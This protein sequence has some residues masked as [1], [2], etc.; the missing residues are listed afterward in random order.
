[1]F[2]VCS[3]LNLRSS[4]VVSA[5]IKGYGVNGAICGAL[6]YG[7]FDQIYVQSE[8]NIKLLS[9]SSSPQIG[10]LFG[11]ITDFSSTNLQVTINNSYLLASIDSLATNKSGGFIGELEMLNNVSVKIINSYVDAN[12]SSSSGNFIG[13]LSACNGAL[14]FTNSYFNNLNGF[15]P[16]FNRS[17]CVVN[18]FP[19]GL[20]SSELYG[21]L[22]INFPSSLWCN[23]RLLIGIIFFIIILLLL[24][25]NSFNR[26]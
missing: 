6:L 12:L 7:Y 2:G 25:K 1:M 26:I 9:T 20:N 18:S 8:V 11:K 22:S 15:D 16:I 14:V 24:I 21:N 5:N 17:G 13:K 19:L 4:G 23:G 3:D 10:G